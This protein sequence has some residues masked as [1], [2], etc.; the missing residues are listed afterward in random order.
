MGFLSNLFN[1][2]DEAINTNADFWN[3]FQKN[4]KTFFKISQSGENIDK[5]HSPLSQKLN[6]LRDG[7]FFLSGMLNEQTAELIITADGNIKNLVFVEELIA[8]APTISGWKFTAHKPELDIKNVSISM[9]GYNFSDKTLSFYAKEYKNH[10]DEIDIVIAN[11]DFTE[12][13]KDQITVGTQIFLDNFLGE[14]NFATTIDNLTVISTNQAEQE[15]IP[16]EKL[17]SYLIWRE[18]EF[19]EKYEGIIPNLTD[20]AHTLYEYTHNN[21]PIIAVINT[22]LLHWEEKVSHPWIIKISIAY[23]GAANNG[24]PNQMI[25]EL[26]NSTGD[27]IT[28]QLENQKNC[29]YIGRETG[30]GTRDI[31]FAS[32]DFRKT[33]LI[34]DTTLKQQT[35][36]NIDYTIYKDKYW[37]TFKPFM[38]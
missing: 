31:F 15:L 16:I 36:F 37:H 26:L 13:N 5:F 20:N 8:D 34:V 21:H 9:N 35:R 25:S 11:T 33:S 6:E 32:K 12:E 29:L 19:V 7:Y 1:K 18:K 23:D 22:D 14:I 27:K 24:M 28:E 2:K 38:R 30:S 3:W 4:E 17:K 10:P